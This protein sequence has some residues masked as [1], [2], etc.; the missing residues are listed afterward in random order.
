[1]NV[2]SVK[3]SFGSKLIVDFKTE[4]KQIVNLMELS[5]NPNVKMKEI[6]YPCNMLQYQINVP[7]ELAESLK[8]YLA[9]NNLSFRHVD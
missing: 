9:K 6:Q 8:S 2:Y 3:P 4:P 1:M 5:I 7:D